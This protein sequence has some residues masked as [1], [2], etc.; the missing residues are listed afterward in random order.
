[1]Q[2]DETSEEVK[3]SRGEAACSLKNKEVESIH[4]LGV[5][6]INPPEADKCSRGVFSPKLDLD[7]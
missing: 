6:K 1:V 3:Q 7:S 4:P 2:Q 5:I